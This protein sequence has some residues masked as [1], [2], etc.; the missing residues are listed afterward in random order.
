LST[1]PIILFALVVAS[2]CGGGGES[3]GGSSSANGGAPTTKMDGGGV[4]GASANGAPPKL[5]L[6]E[7]GRFDQPVHVVAVPGT[8]QMAVVEKGGRVLVV[9][10]MVCSAR[11][12]CPSTPVTQ[13]VT[14][15]DIRSSVSGSSEQGLLGFAFHP[16]WPDDPRIFIDYTDADGA[17]HIEAWSLTSATG[18]ATRERELLRIEQPYENHNGGHVAFGPDGL[19]YIAMGDGGSA[20]DPE[21]RAQ[22]DDERLGKLLRL[23]IDGGGERGYAIPKGNHAGG[24][25]EIWALGLRNPWRF[26]FDRTLGDLWIGDVG[27]DS[28]EEIDAVTKA[29]LGAAETPN[30]EWR[31]REGF[32]SFDD[33]GSIGP[34]T[35]TP[36]VLDYPRKD[37]CSVTGGVVYRG[38]D[39]PALDG[40]YVF[41][42]FCASDLRLLRADGVP[43]SSRT[44][45]ELAW[46]TA[47]GVEQPASFGETQRGEILLVSLGGGIDQI[48]SVG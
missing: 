22:S 1:V 44:R 45:G 12:K 33:A 47:K 13:G 30:F 27:Q 35:R 16:K 36:P 28:F 18:T 15:L 29:S 40:W 46:K 43:G 4:D 39:I 7:V 9:S 31:Q 26:S 32:G 11:D 48:V 8:D 10:G 19:L 41:A 6:R 17:T 5:A 14:V 37:G 38:E 25:P 34:G 42:D 23:D 3:G 20:G 21:D 2:G 24:A